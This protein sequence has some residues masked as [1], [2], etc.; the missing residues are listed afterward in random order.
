VALIQSQDILGLVTGGE[1][2]DRGVREADSEVGV[3]FDD[4]QRAPNIGR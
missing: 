2:D 1:D 4:R 3:P